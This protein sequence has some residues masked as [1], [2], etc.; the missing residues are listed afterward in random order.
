V[1]LVIVPL[2]NFKI[3]DPHI[4][5]LILVL[6]IGSIIF[7]FGIYLLC[8][9]Q[10]TVD[11]ERIFINKKSGFRFKAIKNCWI[12]NDE[13]KHAYPAILLIALDDKDNDLEY[14]QIA[15]KTKYLLDNYITLK[16]KEKEEKNVNRG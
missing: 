11:K 12:Y 5:K 8:K 13:D 16:D 4:L 9:M 10:T 1:A 7:L 3:M 14:R 15:I 6:G 2:L